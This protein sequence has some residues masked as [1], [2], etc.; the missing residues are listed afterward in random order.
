MRKHL[1]KAK[2]ISFFRT[3]NQREATQRLLSRA[4][5]AA[6]AATVRKVAVNHIV[7]PELDGMAN[8]CPYDERVP[9]CSSSFPRDSTDHRVYDS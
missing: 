8:I 2:L 5:A 9:A 4:A 7:V 6:A 1:A 3:I